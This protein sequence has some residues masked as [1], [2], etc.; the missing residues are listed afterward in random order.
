MKLIVCLL[1][2][3][4]LSSCGTVSKQ[5]TQEQNLVAQGSS[6][7]DIKSKNP[8]KGDGVYVID[9]DSEGGLKPIKVLCDMSTQGGGWTLFA[10]HSDGL[11]RIKLSNSVSKTDFSV[12]RKKYWVA[13]RDSMQV[14]MMFIDEGER[15]SMIGAAKLNNG[16]CESI[17][18]M[19]NLTSLSKDGYRHL[20]HHENRG[21]DGRGG[22]Y[23]LISMNDSTYKNNKIAGAALYQ[24]SSMKFDVWPYGGKQFSYDS[25]DTL[26]Y[27][28]K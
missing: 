5:K 27:F 15:V 28:I 8:N 18:D 4:V 2:I 16:S 22:D 26:M 21:C 10:H 6:C 24:S 25:Q 7:A 11:K 13:L 19:N 17:S 3:F 9:V 1:G 23:S 12:L 20:W 14:G